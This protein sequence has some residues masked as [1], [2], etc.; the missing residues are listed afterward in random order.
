MTI[1]P[2]DSADAESVVAFALRAWAPVFVSIEAALEPEVYRALYPDW[3]ASQR[4]AVEDAL[5]EQRVWVAEEDGAPVGFVS[6]ALH[7]KDRMGE[8]YMLAVDP[9][10]QRRGV[11]MALTEHA[12]EWMREAGMEVAMI[13][14]G[15]DPGHGPARRAYERAGFRAFPVVQYYKKL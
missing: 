2:Y 1:R 15:G 9:D 12:V 10:Y 3:R 4:K 6:V 8:V 7:E 11:G 5:A 14:T 13:N